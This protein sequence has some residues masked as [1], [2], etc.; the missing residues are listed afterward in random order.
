MMMFISGAA[1]TLFFIVLGLYLTGLRAP[2]RQDD[3]T[4][5]AHGQRFQ[6]TVVLDRQSTIEGVY[7]FGWRTVET[8]EK[9]PGALRVQINDLHDR[10]TWLSQQ[11]EGEA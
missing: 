6:R 4:Y 2:K 3:G 5:T 7:Q 8:G 9:A 10:H 1:T 11:K